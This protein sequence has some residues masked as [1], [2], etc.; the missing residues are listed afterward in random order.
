MR[1]DGALLPVNHQRLRQPSIATHCF[2]SHTDQHDSCAFRLGDTLSPLWNS[3]CNLH[4]ADLWPLHRL[5]NSSAPAVLLATVATVHAHHVQH[6]CCG[7]F[8]EPDSPS[9]LYKCD[10]EHTNT[11]KLHRPA[12]MPDGAQSTKRRRTPGAAACLH[13]ES[14]ESIR[15]LAPQLIVV[16]Q[17]PGAKVFADYQACA[18]MLTQHSH[19]CG[20]HVCSCQT[21]SA[22]LL[23]KEVVPLD[24]LPHNTVRSAAAM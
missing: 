2:R 24:K 20:H 8:R 21:Y 14:A 15:P 22:H 5:A 17:S 11:I 6:P 4:R 13:S 18:G 1:R 10:A 7:S 3:R 12:T 23:G 9:I 19:A 16:L